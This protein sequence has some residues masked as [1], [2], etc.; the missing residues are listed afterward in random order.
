MNQLLVAMQT[1]IGKNVMVGSNSSLVAPITI[2]DDAYIA[3]GSTVTESVDPQSLVIAR[4]HQV[5]KPNRG[6]GRMKST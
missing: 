5:T 1:N 3:A 4:A 6:I 2:G